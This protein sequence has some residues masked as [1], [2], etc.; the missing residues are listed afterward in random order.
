MNTLKFSASG[1]FNAA[2]LSFMLTTGLS[3]CG[4]SGSGE[5]PTPA[6]PPVA[7]P[8]SNPPGGEYRGLDEFSIGN[9]VAP[10]NSWMT[11]WTLN[12]LVKTTG[13]END[14]LSAETT[15]WHY[16]IDGTWYMEDSAQI[17]TDEAGWP[18]QMN[19][20]NGTRPSS[21]VTVVLGGDTANAY[22]SGDYQLTY[23][24]EGS[25]I[26]S[27]AEVIAESSGSMTLRYDGEGAI[28]LEITDT[29]PLANGNYLRNIALTRPGAVSGER[30]HT[31][32][33]DYA[34]PFSTIRPLHM[35][36]EEPVYALADAQGGYSYYQGDDAWEK[37]KQL[38]DAG[39]GGAMGAPYE[40]MID[41]A[42][43]SASDLWL[44]LPLA[45]D[46]AYL[47]QLA[48]LVLAELDDDRQL[49]IELGNELWN[50]SYPYALGREYAYQAAQQRW[51][52]VAGSIPHYAEDPIDENTM[53]FSWLAAR[54]IEAGNLFKAVWGDQAERVKVVL[55][56]QFGA[57][58]PEWNLNRLILEAP[59][60]VNEEN[61][62]LPANQIDAFA[63]GAYVNDP[64]QEGAQ[65]LPGGFDR[66]SP[67][68]FITDA[69][70][71]I[72]GVEQ[73]GETAQEPGMRY[74]VRSDVAL[75]SEYNLPLIAYEGGHHFIGSRFTR[76]E[77]V[78]NALMYEVYQALF[79]MW[80]EEGAGLFVHLHGIIQR[81]QN[82]E[83]VEPGYFESENF[84]I[85][86]TQQQTENE[87]PRY[88]AVMDVIRSLE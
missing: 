38:T 36:G 21:F 10:I 16:T 63:V 52:G 74:S 56:G 31:D 34:T 85:K 83:G 57:S 76:D 5:E 70:N 25:L 87:A 7:P 68:A 28:Y 15:Y 66:S 22:A 55:A 72:N 73:F 69:I 14:D 11:A 84:G 67:E 27:N 48:Q 71:Y 42:N 47:T 9:A 20:Q 24:G 37:R 26:V 29:D 33:I 88:R 45:A 44:N 53:I 35:S 19:L 80:Q 62:E 18:V 50:W 86:E 32:Y 78:P 81:G 17:V 65:V 4:G 12:D 13:F 39:W 51:P 6:P 2:I 79:T 41:L 58:T 40:V 60:Y 43:Q 23:E 59:V 77:V 3:G 49:I 8:V 1:V 54:T 46:D 64:Y 75:A 30:F 61:A 82:E